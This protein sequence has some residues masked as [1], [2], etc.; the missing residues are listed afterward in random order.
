MKK[1]KQSKEEIHKQIQRRMNKAKIAEI[2]EHVIDL[3]GQN[4]TRV[5]IETHLEKKYKKSNSQVQAYVTKAYIKLNEIHDENVKEKRINL[6]QGFRADMHRAF[7]QY[8]NQDIPPSIR[9]KYFVTYLDIKMR[10]ASFEKDG[11]KQESEANDE[12]TINITFNKVKK[13]E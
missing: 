9:H 3:L 4:L 2:T 12:K 5:Q 10:M 7:E 6:I 13:D 11:L 1:V 8:Q